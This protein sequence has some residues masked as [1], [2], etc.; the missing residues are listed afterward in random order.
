MKKVIL[1]LSFVISGVLSLSAQEV[2]TKGTCYNEYYAA[3]RDRGSLPVPD[4]ERRVVVSIRKDY[5]CICF[6]G[7]IKVVGGKPTNSLVI[8]RQDSTFERFE[9]VA[10]PK[11]A[12]S[13][14]KFV[15]Y[16]LNGMSPTYLSS[17]DEMINL[18]FID[19]LRPIPAKYKEA[20]PIQNK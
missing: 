7:R 14:T 9:F 4:G 11:Y 20:P 19:Y 10:H 12:R 5:D 6:M 8:E 17:N 1:L 18:F 15:N 16:I 13:E 3:F 2:A